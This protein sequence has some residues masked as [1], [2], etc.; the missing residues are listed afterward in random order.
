MS[1]RSTT[2]KDVADGVRLRGPIGEVWADGTKVGLVYEW[3]LVG[4]KADWRLEAERYRLDT[5]ADDKAPSR[6][7]E[8]RLDMR[9]GMVKAKGTI[10]TEPVRD[11][12]SH[13][14]IVVKGRTLSWSKQLPVE[15][16]T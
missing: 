16:Q 8:L 5:P 11:G 10:W 4:W 15:A 14:A 12:H 3:L 1:L 7:V 13:R 2:L 6:Y 9:I